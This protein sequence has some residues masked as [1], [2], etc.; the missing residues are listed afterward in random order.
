M[1][2]GKVKIIS[3]ETTLDRMGKKQMVNPYRWSRQLDAEQEEASKAKEGDSV[4]N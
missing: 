3:N 1:S 4:I 2:G